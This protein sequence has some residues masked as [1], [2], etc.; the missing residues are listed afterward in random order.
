MS[1]TTDVVRLARGRFALR[2][3]LSSSVFTTGVL[4][5]AGLVPSAAHAAD[6]AAQTAQT[7]VVEEVVVTGTRIVRD[8]YEAPTPLTVVTAEALQ[9]NAGTN[10]AEAMHAIPAF[11]GSVTPQT[12]ITSVSASG[13]GLNLLNLRSLGSNRTLILLDGQRTVPSRVDAVV[14]INNIPQQLVQRVDIVT[15]GASAIYGSDAVTGVVNFILDKTF[16]G[17]KGEISGG[18]T[19]YGDDRNYKVALTAGTA[20]AGGRGHFIVS[21][22]MVNKDGVLDHHRPWNLNQIGVINNTAANIAAGQPQRLVRSGV[23]SWFT[24]GGTIQSGPLKG[25]TFGPGGVPYM[26][27]FGSITDTAYTA[28]G[29]SRLGTIR[30]DTG[31]LDPSENRQAVFLR[32]SYEV[33][34]YINLFA[35]TSWNSSHNFNWAFSHFMVGNGPT[36]LSGNPMIRPEIQAQMTALKI[37]SIQVSGMNYDLP[38]I[39]PDLRRRTMRYVVGG[40]GAF[41]AFDTSWKWN[42]YWQKGV[43]LI[44]YNALGATRRTLRLNAIDVVRNANGVI[45]CRSTLTNPNDGCV[46]YNPMGLGVNSA[47]TINYITNGGEHPHTNQHIGQDVIAAD[48]NGEPFSSWAGPVSVALSVERRVESAVSKPSAATLYS[49]WHSGNFLPFSGRYSVNEGAGEIIIP[50]AKDTSFAES[51]DLSAAVRATSYSVQGYVTTWKL[52]T[53]YQPVSDIR[54]RASRSRDIRAPSLQDLYNTVLGGFLL[55]FDPVCQ[56]TAS[57]FGTT[58]G[59]PN[60]T[61]ETADTTDIGVVLQPRFFPGFSA[62]VDYW[63]IDLGNA[64]A[65]PSLNQILTFCYQGLQSYCADITRVNGVVTAM[66]QRPVNIAQQIT[67]GIDFEAS[68]GVALNEIVSD[69]EG[70]V[71]LHIQATHYIKNYSDTKLAPPTDNVGEMSGGAPPHWSGVARLDYTNDAMSTALTYRAMSSGTLRNT[72]VECQTGCPTNLV[73]PYQSIDNNYGPGYY[74]FDWSITRKFELG[75]SAAEAFL[76]VNNIFNRDPGITPKGS[77]EI[78]YEISA[79]NPSKYDVLGRVFKVGLRFKM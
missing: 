24:R 6:A 30:N 70:R 36:I 7:P 51:W 1:L 22:E 66:T 35:Q 9:Q 44:N 23:D 46:P 25:I 14:D 57:P 54:V 61:P 42:A 13:A 55:A 15:G 68:Y 49:D 50:L 60:L 48:I 73:S 52:G 77:D 79:S 65:Q 19:T 39:G 47:A 34:D 2:R 43:S 74:Y 58:M 37:T 64:I 26:F 78:G 27:N 45:V 29:D 53:T 4:L 41:D 12:G 3:I 18:V 11:A 16:T 21:G 71:G 69:W 62:S 59:N 33:N 17:I 63:N 76:N 40:N 5:Q 72:Y 31:T 20:F 8:G 75:G 10:I 67:R 28:G 56:C 38:W 32:T